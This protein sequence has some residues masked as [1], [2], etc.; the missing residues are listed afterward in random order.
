MTNKLARHLRKTLL[1]G[2]FSAIPLAITIGVIVYIEGKSRE[3]VRALLGVDIPFVGILIAVAL[4]YLIGLLVSSLVGKLLLDW[5]DRLLSRMPVLREVYQAWKQI[6][7]TPGGGEGIYSRVVL[8]PTAGPGS[9]MV[10]AFTSGESIP[11]DPERCCVFIPDAPNPMG[12]ALS[13]AA[14]CECIPLGIPAE[15]AFKML[16]SGG[17]YVPEAI[18][19]ALAPTTPA[20]AP[21]PPLSLDPP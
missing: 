6:L 20:P 5:L 8:V 15:E 18:G 2:V 7:I 21:A 1:T 12:G 14:I 19:A 10:L 13:V 4:I 16:L 17:N 11:G 9:R 3:P